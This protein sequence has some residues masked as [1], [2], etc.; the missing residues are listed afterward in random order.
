MQYA[1][2]KGVDVI[3]AA[4]NENQNL[5]DPKV[6]SSSPNN[7]TYDQ[8]IQN[9][10]V[11]L[12][13]NF[14]AIEVISKRT[15]VDCSM[16]NV[17]T[18]AYDLPLPVECRQM[19]LSPSPSLSVLMLECVHTD[20]A[21]TMSALL[22]NCPQLPLELSGTVGVSALGINRVKASYS[23]YGSLFVHVSAFWMPLV[24]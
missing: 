21:G 17:C 13:S 15:A 19:D 3:V 2:S 18:P 22:Q 24:C 7:V 5:D 23:N 6:D 9:R 1:L 4:G 20:Q 14:A 11:D 16:S 10:P 12:V 8:I